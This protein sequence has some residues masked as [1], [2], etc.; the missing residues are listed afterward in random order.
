MGSR[1]VWNTAAAILVVGLTF[2]L[3][4]VALGNLIDLT[5][6]PATGDTVDWGQ[7]GLTSPRVPEEPL[8]TLAVHS[9][10]WLF[11][12]AASRL[13]WDPPETSMAILRPALLYWSV[14][15]Q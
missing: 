7:L 1:L 11:S 9:P 8:K 6:R 14:P 15:V 3:P 10:F 13:H 4:R 2:V 12:N 5:S